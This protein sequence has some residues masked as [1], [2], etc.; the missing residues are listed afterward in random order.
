MN[1]NFSGDDQ[2]ISRDLPLT[3]GRLINKSFEFKERAYGWNLRKTILPAPVQPDAFHP[4]P[5]AAVK[6]G[7]QV[8]SNMPASESMDHHGIHFSMKGDGRH[9][10]TTQMSRSIH[11]DHGKQPP[12]D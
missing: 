7:V 8:V 9:Y 10:D 11:N 5:C 1:V 3:T 6:I 4:R 2:R 12:S